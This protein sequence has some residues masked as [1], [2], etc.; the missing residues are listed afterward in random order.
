MVRKYLSD[1]L[2]DNLSKDYPITHAGNTAM[3][4]MMK[5]EREMLNNPIEQ[6]TQQCMHNAKLLKVN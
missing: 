3:P 2:C 1:N 6:N 4:I 5:E